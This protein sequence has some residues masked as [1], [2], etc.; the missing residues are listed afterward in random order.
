MTGVVTSTVPIFEDSGH[1]G[2]AALPKP[3]CAS[4]H[5]PWPLA[6]AGLTVNPAGSV[7]EALRTGGV[8]SVP[9]VSLCGIFI[10]TSKPVGLSAVAVSGCA[11]RDASKCNRLQPVTGGASAVADAQ[12][13]SVRS[14]VPSGL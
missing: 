2:A 11:P 3:I 10:A 6:A 13:G 4:E 14:G 7:T 12:F 1:V 9:G 8:A 5:A